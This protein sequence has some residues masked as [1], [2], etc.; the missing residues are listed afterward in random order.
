MIVINDDSLQTLNIIPRNSVI[1][2]TVS[3]ITGDTI[4]A[5]SELS[6]KFIEEETNDGFSVFNQESVKYDNYLA[7]QVNIS[8]NLR[9][10]FNYFMTITKTSNQKLVYRDKIMVLADSDIP[11][12]DTS[13]HSI[14]DGEYTAYTGSSSDNEYI[15]LDD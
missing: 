9:K 6:V 4:A 8:N 3:V 14:N 12:T 1:D 5:A 2:Y 15:I 11:Y 13:N 7:L 10:N